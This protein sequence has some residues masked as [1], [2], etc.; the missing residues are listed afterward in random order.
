MATKQVSIFP[1]D[2][3]PRKAVGLSYPFSNTGVRGNSPFK[4]NYTT[5]D[6]IKSNLFVYF[7]TDVGERYLNPDYG[8]NFKQFVFEQVNA[9]TYQNIEQLIKDDLALY[10]PQVELK[11]LEVT[12]DPDELQINIGMTYAIFNNEEDTLEINLNA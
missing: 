4:L 6:Q 3:Q 5:A 10:F 12:G 7:S 1:L 8:S 9:G 11:S 2:Q